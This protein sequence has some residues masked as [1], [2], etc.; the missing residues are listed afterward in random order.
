MTGIDQWQ[1]AQTPSDATRRPAQSHRPAGPGGRPASRGW[2]LA[3]GLNAVDP[4]QY[5][6][7]AG[8]LIACEADARDM[9]AIATGV[10]C[11]GT[12]LLTQEATS[13]RVLAELADAAQQLRPGD[14]FILSYS[15]HGGQLGDAND[16]EADALDETWCLFDRMLIDDELYA[17]WARFAPGVRIVVLSD[18]CHSGTVARMAR[19]EFVAQAVG[20]MAVTNPRQAGLSPPAGAIKA[21]PFERAWPVYQ[22][23]KNFYDSLQYLCG[24]ADKANI[25]ASVILISGCQ[26]NQLSMDGMDNG[27]FTGTLKRVWADGQYGRDYESFCRDIIRLMPPSQT[28]NYYVVG[29]ANAGFEAQRPF[30]V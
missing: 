11:T 25:G 2:Y 8:P 12:L 14:L 20:M 18:S 13:A 28:P 19:Y 29:A 9:A 6:G 7:W 10:G 26:D 15:G 23:R 16:E 21:I 30:S 24:P 3:I 1:G 4:A 17:M 27:L 22:E 5:G